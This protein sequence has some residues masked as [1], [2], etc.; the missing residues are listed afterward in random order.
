VRAAAILVAALAAC[1]PKVV[2]PTLE[3]AVDP[4]PNPALSAARVVLEDGWHLDPAEVIALMDESPRTYVV[5]S[6]RGPLTSFHAPSAADPI[7]PDTL[8]VVTRGEQRD[9]V[10][11]E[12]PPTVV[13]FVA[14]ARLAEAGGDPGAALDLLRRVTERSPEWARGWRLAGEA[15]TAVEPDAAGAFFAEAVRLAPHDAYTWWGLARLR[16]AQGDTGDAHAALV[17]AWVLNP[18]HP[19]ILDAL[20]AQLGSEGRRIDHARLDLP[21]RVRLVRQGTVQVRLSD[22]T[23]LPLAQCLAVWGYEGALQRTLV[24]PE[25]LPVVATRSCFASQA[26]GLEALEASGVQLPPRARRFLGASRAGMMESMVL[27]DVFGYQAPRRIAALP[28][29]TVDRIVEYVDR[30]VIVT[31]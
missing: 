13:D 24:V 12:A 30:F 5:Q 10:P 19:G 6:G 18:H 14:A 9:V 28:P 17:R 26:M 7:V 8:V 2:A 4:R 15:A 11:D 27:W 23:W 20:E 31:D 3:A 21:F 22:P 1:G 16:A 25:L 29:E